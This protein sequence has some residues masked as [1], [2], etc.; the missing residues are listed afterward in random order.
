MI[1]LLGAVQSLFLLVFKANGDP[2]FFST[3][4]VVSEYL[5]ITFYLLN[6]FL[7]P[8]YV[9]IEL[10]KIADHQQRIKMNFHMLKR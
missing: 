2:G 4:P 9:V 3:K 1:Y 5:S 6:I 8:V 7:N 10:F